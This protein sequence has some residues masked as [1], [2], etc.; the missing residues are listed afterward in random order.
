MVLSCKLPFLY[1]LKS[2]QRHPIPKPAITFTFLK[3]ISNLVARLIPAVWI[4]MEARDPI[5]YNLGGPPLIRGKSGQP[6]VDG[7]NNCQAKSFIQRGLHESSFC[8]GY[9]TIKLTVSISV[10]LS[11]YPSHLPLQLSPEKTSQGTTGS[12]I[13][14]ANSADL[15]NSWF[16]IL[17]RS[18]LE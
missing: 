13:T 18:D 4:D 8:V 14:K 5:D 10:S 12:E 15:A 9:T 2:R 6:I 1:P 17:R 11:S 16:L 7:L 3:E